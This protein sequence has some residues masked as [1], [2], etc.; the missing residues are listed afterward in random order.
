MTRTPRQPK[1]GP[2]PSQDGALSRPSP[3]ASELEAQAAI[4]RRELLAKLRERTA[5][6]SSKMRAILREEIGALAQE[7]RT[8]DAQAQALEVAELLTWL[9]GDG[10][11][12]AHPI[13]LV[14][15]DP[16]RL[17]RPRRAK[18]RP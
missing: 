12:P 14:S 2:A 17:A 10:P 11:E 15:M 18:A 8:V 13:E 9:N 3:T 4:L 16:C 7:I 6:K 1:I 5:V